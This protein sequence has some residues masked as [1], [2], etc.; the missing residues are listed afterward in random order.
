MFASF[1]PVALDEACVD[2]C[3]RQQPL[4]DSQLADNMAAEGFCDHH[5]HFI[6]N[7]PETDWRTCLEHAE[8]IGVGTRSY[9][10]VRVR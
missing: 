8:K 2:A 9:E 3:N 6:N 4:P 5:D 7:S 10:L 1:D